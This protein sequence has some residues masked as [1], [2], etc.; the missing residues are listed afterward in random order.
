MEISARFH[1]LLSHQLAQFADRPELSSLVVYL[2]LPREGGKPGLIAVDQ[3]P[4]EAMALPGVKLPAVDEDSSLLLPSTERRWFPL[5]RDHLLLGALRVETTDLP[6]Q[7]A[8]NDRLQAVAHCLTEA[9]LLDQ[10]QQRLQRRLE[11]QGQQLRLLVHQL[12]NPLAALRTFGQLLKRRLEGDAPNRTLVEG[13]LAEERQLNRYVDAIDSLDQPP[14]LGPGVSDPRPLLLPPALN[15][16]EPQILQERLEPLLIRAAATASLQG[17]TW[18]GPQRCPDWRGD[19]AAVAEILANLLENA[20]RYSPDGAA[21]GLQCRQGKG[22]G[23]GLSLCVWDGG[24]AISAREREAIFERGVRGERSKGRSGSG[25]GL[26]LARELAGTLGGELSLIQPP[27]A[28]DAS[29]P[30]EGNA[31]C[32]ELPPSLPSA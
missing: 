20:F 25:L 14:T 12:R 26:A 5:Q 19:S 15:S 3:W 9:L 6:W 11:L 1:R 29:L 21:V 23:R 22:D 24:P 7:P 30:P 27:G 17:R 31:F 16:K 32:L 10:D 8:L 2:A 28:F 18:T 13:L 4:R